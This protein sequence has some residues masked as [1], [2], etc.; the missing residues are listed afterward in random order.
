MLAQ[1]PRLAQRV[2]AIALIVMIAAIAAAVFLLGRGWLG[3]PV[4]VRV[5]FVRSGGLRDHAPIVVAGQPIGRIEALAP[6]LH[7]PLLDGA[8]GVAA[9]VAIDADQAWKVPAASEV[10]VASRGALGDRYLEVAPPREPGA[11]VR[12]GQ[13]LRGIDP[14][15]LDNVLQHTWTNMTIFKIFMEQ[16]RPEVEKLEASVADL[17]ATLR[18]LPAL[19]PVLDHVRAL[20]TA[21]GETEQAI[22]FA[23]V[24]ATIGDARQTVAQVR[25][26]LDQL[27]PRL[28]ALVADARRIHGALAAA[29]PI[30]RAERLVDQLQQAIGKLDPLVARL[31]ELAARVAAGEGSIGRLMQD[32]E[33]PEDTK[34][35]GKIMKRQPW[36]ILAKP[37]PD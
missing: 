12:D 11:R 19:A 5:V 35:L 15:S 27:R 33:F 24:S 13:T 25:A 20:R 21:V 23:A 9:L 6:A 10:F 32:P 3:T 22:D 37:P 34:E 8:S 7:E 4:R 30:A 18:S 2:G 28:Q 36:K 29:E 17:R 31:D 14:P 26:A 1:D 16:V